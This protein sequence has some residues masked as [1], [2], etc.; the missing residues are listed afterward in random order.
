MRTGTVC[1]RAES[2]RRQPEVT[3]GLEALVGRAIQSGDEQDIDLTEE[4][5]VVTTKTVPVERARLGARTET[6]QEKVSAQVRKES[7][8]LVD[9]HDTSSRGGK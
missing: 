1:Y 5:V 9:Q 7:I 8:E 6:V 4:Q 3:V 2:L